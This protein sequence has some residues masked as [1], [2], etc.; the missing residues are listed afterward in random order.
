MNSNTD[1]D[2]NKKC[3][4]IR[5]QRIA[6]AWLPGKGRTCRYEQRSAVTRAC[7]LIGPFL[8]RPEAVFSKVVQYFSHR[9]KGYEK[10][11]NVVH[12]GDGSGYSEI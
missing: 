1:L 12:P 4:V 9:D 10:D 7:V 3:G 6:E 5:N 8:I 11:L 2:L